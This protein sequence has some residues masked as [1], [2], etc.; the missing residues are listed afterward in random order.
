M[1]HNLGEINITKALS[2][3]QLGI[4][5]CYTCLPLAL[6]QTFNKTQYLYITWTY[7]VTVTADAHEKVIWFDVSVDEVLC[8]YILN[9]ADH[10]KMKISRG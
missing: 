2:V 8:V 4:R 6:P 1:P 9:S 10:L 3:D 5:N 7:L